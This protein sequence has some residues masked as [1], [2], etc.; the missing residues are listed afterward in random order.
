V[1]RQEPLRKDKKAR[2]GDADILAE[3]GDTKLTKGDVRRAIEEAR[4]RVG[5][6]LAELL[7]APAMTEEEM[8]GIE[9]E[10]EAE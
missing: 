7:I 4:E 9:T 3:Q 5:P 10:D 6:E 8:D 2:L 1:K